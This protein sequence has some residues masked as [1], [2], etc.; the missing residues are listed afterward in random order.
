MSRSAR[1]GRAPSLKG[2]GDGVDGERGGVGAG[3]VA[4][5]HLHRRLE[6]PVVA[7]RG[8]LDLRGA[9][10]GPGWMGRHTMRGG[11]ALG[12]LGCLQRRQAY[13]VHS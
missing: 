11:S 5:K 6:A 3:L 4:H 1:L 12:A 8:E 13:N 9:R 7:L 2:A 10:A